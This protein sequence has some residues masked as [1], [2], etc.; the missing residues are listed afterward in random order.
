M[1]HPDIHFHA[2]TQREITELLLNAQRDFAMPFEIELLAK[3]GSEVV[4]VLGKRKLKRPALRRLSFRFLVER[5]AHLADDGGERR[6]ISDREL[7]EHLAVESDVGC[8]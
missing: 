8:L 5:R 3:N 4:A 1:Q 2:W 7:G 6:L